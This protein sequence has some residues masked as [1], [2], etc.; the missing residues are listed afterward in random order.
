M[1]KALWEKLDGKKMKLGGVAALLT[2]L[3]M[4]VQKFAVDG[5]LSEEGLG[6]VWKGWLVIAAKSA[7]EKAGTA[8]KVLIVALC[9]GAIPWRPA[10]AE[11]SLFDTVLSEVHILDNLTPATFY[12]VKESQWMG[13]GTTELYQ[14]YYIGAVLGVAKPLFSDGTPDSSRALFNTGF[15]FHGGTFLVDKIPAL[16]ELVDGNKLTAGLLKYGTLGYWGAFDFTNREFRH[17]PYGGFEWH[18]GGGGDAAISPDA[19]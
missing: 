9:L 12:D 6:L 2:G 11:G 4:L 15:N 3:G 1:L 13:G 18:F 19:A 17:G 7:I 10:M 14:K 5:G 8:A 16:K